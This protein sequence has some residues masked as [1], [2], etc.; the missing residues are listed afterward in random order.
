MSLILSKKALQNLIVRALG[1]LTK[2][3]LEQWILSYPSQ[4]ILLALQI[5]WTKKVHISLEKENPKEHLQAYENFLVKR[6]EIVS[7]LMHKVPFLLKKSN[8]CRTTSI[9]LKDSLLVL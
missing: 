1:E 4:I 3:T 7:K 2:V 9:R 5:A 8:I 6:I